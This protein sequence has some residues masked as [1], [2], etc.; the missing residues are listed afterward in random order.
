MPRYR[1]CSRRCWRGRSMPMPRS[2]VRF[3]PSCSPPWP[4]CWPMSTSSRR[5]WPAG[6]PGPRCPIRS[7]RPSSIRTTNPVT[8]PRRQRTLKNECADCSPASLAGS[9]RRRGQRPGRPDRR[10][11]DP[12]HDGAAPAAL[13]PGPAVHLQYRH[14]R[15][16][17]DG[18]GPYGKAAGLRRLP[19][20]AAADHPDA[21]VAERGLHPRRAA[22]GPHRHRHGRQGDRG[23]RPLPDRRQ[24]RGRP[25]RLRHPG[26]DQLHRGDQGC[27]AHRRGR[28]ALH[29]GCHARQADGG[30]RR[31]ERRPDQRGRGQAPPCRAG[32]RGRLLRL[33]GRCQQVRA[34]R[35]GRRHAD[36]GHQYRRRL[37]HR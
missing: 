7:C 27:G 18:G 28:R 21:P 29:P 26:G 2:T 6:A 3:P 1:C 31:P 37:H 30:G 25:D 34:R 13:R 22:G 9:A 20:R 4:R 36:P 11:P 5:P 17:H 32:R 33:H 23:L 14:G 12:V 19:D 24:L 8:R 35:R 16:G 10:D 15:D